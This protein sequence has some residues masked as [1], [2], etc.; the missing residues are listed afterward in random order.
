MPASRACLLLPILL[1]LVLPVPAIFAAGNAGTQR[2]ADE[3]LAETCTD[4]ADCIARLRLIAKI[5]HSEK[6]LGMG[7]AEDALA[8]RLL[9]MPGAADALVPLLADPEQS[10]ADLAAYV[11]RDMPTIDPKHLPGIRIG[12]DRD[13][14]WLA[15]ALARIGTDEAA[16]EAVKRLL[17]KGETGNQEAY[18]VELFGA[19]ALPHFLDA[20]ECPPGC[21]MASVFDAL[22]AVLHSMPAAARAQ[23]VPGLLQRLQQPSASD[24]TAAGVL[25]LLSL[26]GA[27]AREAEPALLELRRRRPALA[28]AID[29]TLIAIAAPAAATI[30]ERRIEDRPTNEDLERLGAIGAPGRIAVPKLIALLKEGGT[31]IDPESDAM[32]WDFIERNDLPMTAAQALGAIGNPSAAAALA[33]AI[34]D[35]YDPR[36]NWAA[37]QALARLGLPEYRPVL[38]RAAGEHWYPLVRNAARRTLDARQPVQSPEDGDALLMMSSLPTSDMF[39]QEDLSCMRADVETRREPASRKLGGPRH[40]GA[41]R[42]LQYTANVIGFGPP[43][44]A[45]PDAQGVTRMTTA[46]AVRRDSA[47]AQTP[48][49]ALRAERGWLVGG[50][51][52]EWGGE[53]VWIGDD[54]LRQ[55]ILAQN[56]EDIHR[57]GDRIVATSGIAHLML[58]QGA[59]YEVARDDDGHWR[60]R[61]W[62]ILPGAPT[63]S[64]MTASGELLVNTVMG[65]PLLIDAQGRMRTAPCAETAR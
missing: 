21:D 23:A 41:L 15:P 43:E 32:S 9:A 49:V 45:Q 13:L 8:K 14:G 30:L 12:L 56:I 60:A 10:V 44:G 62:R 57:L 54:G 50:N 53:L 47:I 16:A 63:E 29:E 59:V 19:R 36:L 6:S 20:V 51:R 58:N 39:G 3:R 31:W 38:E 5:R 48:H 24:D 46:D 40:A 55:T 27:S 33:Q 17:A 35:P 26:I 7:R 52:G 61:P 64:G 28:L 11:L 34:G 37:V 18:A 42:K 25:Y 22:S 4:L 1:L 2:T 65:G